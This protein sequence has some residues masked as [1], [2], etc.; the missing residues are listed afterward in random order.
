MT[1]QPVVKRVVVLKDR[2]ELTTVVA[3]RFLRKLAARTSAGQL[4]HVCLT[5]G[6][7]GTAVLRTVGASADREGVDWNLVHIWWGDERFVPREDEE[8]L[9][10]AARE[11][12]LDR[13]AIPAENIHAIAA[14]DDG[15]DLDEAAAKYERELAQF[16][17]EDRAWPSFDVC[18]LGVGP[19]GHIASLFPDRTEIQITDR[20]AVPVR[21]SPS[22]RRSGSV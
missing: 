1:E 15:E 13:I 4:T 16:G 19:D 21:H 14:S 3:R 20:S 12:L 7:V 9:E 8:R 5:G 11:A 10:R 6:T 2:E 18:F 17:S 22:R